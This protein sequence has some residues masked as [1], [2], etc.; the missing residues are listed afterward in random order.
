MEKNIFAL[1]TRCKFRF[2]FKGNI[3]VEDLWDLSVENLDTVYK[4]LKKRLKDNCEDSLLNT[5]DA[6]ETTVENMLA[7]VQYIFDVKVAEAEARCAENEKRAKKQRIA[8]IIADKQDQ[9]L[10]NMSIEELQAMLN[11]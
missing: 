6:R 8:A 9:A 7:I 2:P 3:S 5:K 4:T 11:E 1:A 10:V